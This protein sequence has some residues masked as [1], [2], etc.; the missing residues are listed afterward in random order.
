MKALQLLRLVRPLNLIIILFTQYMVRFAFF[1]PAFR[2]AGFSLQLNESVFAVFSLAFVFMAAG[3]YV[4]N[5]YYDVEIDKINRPEKVIVGE[6]IEPKNILTAYWV[7]SLSGVIMGC[8]A[9]VKSG[10]PV[11][12]TVFLF[13]LV[14]LWFYSKN[15]KYQFLTGNITVALFL[16]LVPLTAGIIELYADNKNPDFVKSGL[17]LIFLFYCIMGISLFAFL[18]SFAREIVKDMEDM[19]GDQTMGCRTLP[20]V[21]GK[22]AARRIVQFLLLV[23]FFLLCYV[24][25]QQWVVKDLKSFIYFSVFIQLPIIF[26]IAKMNGASVPKDYHKASNWLKML[27]VSGI[28]YLFVFAYTC[29]S[30]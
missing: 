9:S 8:F 11:L 7:L 28:C 6:H 14:G 2:Y 12:S 4:I 1:Y 29:L 21:M 5:D 25:Y 30:Q 18:S 26:I 15:L 27:M 24:Q 19:E 3:G 20:I 13:Y 10:L 16:A 23:M 22:E 17:N